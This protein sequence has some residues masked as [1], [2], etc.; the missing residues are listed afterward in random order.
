METIDD[1]FRHKGHRPVYS[2]RPQDTVAAALKVMS[3]CDAGAILVMNDEKI[4]GIF[5]ERDN[6]RKTT[7]RNQSPESTLVGDVMVKQVIYVSPDYK[8]SECLAI[9]ESKKIRHL[10]VLD[11]GQVIA[12]VGI[13]DV[14]GS[15]IEDQEFLIGELTKYITGGYMC[16][17]TVAHPA[18]ELVIDSKLGDSRIAL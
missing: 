7:I 18:K 9:M 5:S 1:L 8:L 17:K 2:V 16:E 13:Q 6:A 12:L 10:P 4:V 11:Q 3:D 15:L 14:S